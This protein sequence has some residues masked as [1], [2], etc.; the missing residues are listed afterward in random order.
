MGYVQ[1][2]RLAGAGM[3]PTALLVLLVTSFVVFRGWLPMMWLASLI[4]VFVIWLVRPLLPQQ[5]N[6][7]RRLPLLG[8]RFSPKTHEALL[9]SPVEPR[10][11]DD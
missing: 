5:A 7:N 3:M 8:S 4:T 2:E 6:P 11:V 10:G 1:R 9:S